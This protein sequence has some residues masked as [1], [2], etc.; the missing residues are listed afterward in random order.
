M[1]NFRFAFEGMSQKTV[2]NVNKV[3]WVFK[4][5][6]CWSSRFH[7]FFFSPRYNQLERI[8]L[9]PLNHRFYHGRIK[10]DNAVSCDNRFKLD[11]SRS[12]VKFD[13][14][15][16]LVCWFVLF[17]VYLCSVLTL[18][19]QRR[20]DTQKFRFITIRI[21]SWSM[22]PY[23]R[24]INTNSSDILIVSTKQVN[25]DFLNMFVLFLYSVCL[26]SFLPL[27]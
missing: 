27:I 21:Q 16:R 19:P 1:R 4:T 9:I 15:Y 18:C 5:T 14:F 25:E 22:K 10:M 20:R 8:C 24:F 12:Y 13:F 2:K 11:I 6:W 3:P 17:V 23:T 26:G 7:F